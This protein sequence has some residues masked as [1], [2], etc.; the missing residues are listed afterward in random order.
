MN[1]GKGCTTGPDTGTYFFF[2]GDVSKR[3]FSFY[4]RFLSIF[5]FLLVQLSAQEKSPTSSA[6]SLGFTQWL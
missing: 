3:N 5:S 6:S 2:L 1:R 4:H